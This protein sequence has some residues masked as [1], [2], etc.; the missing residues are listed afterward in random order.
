MLFV[1]AAGNVSFCP[2]LTQ[3]ES[4]KFLAGNIYS[5]SVKDIW[6]NSP[7]FKKF[8]GVQCRN[9]R[10][11][12]FRD[13]CKGGCRSRAFLSVNDI[14]APDLEMCSLYGFQPDRF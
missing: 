3:R 14:N 11:C 9:V 7:V 13:L 4:P 1:D 5:A 6:E 2:T 8:R 10:T 12:P